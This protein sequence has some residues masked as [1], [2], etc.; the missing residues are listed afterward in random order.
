METYDITAEDLAELVDQ[1]Q[2]RTFAEEISMIE[3]RGGE[4]KILEK[5]RTDRQTGIVSAHKEIRESFFGTNQ[6]KKSKLKSMWEFFLE[7]LNDFTLKILM[8]AAVVSISN[9]SFSI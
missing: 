5:L 7:A 6:K 8:A 1:L 2:Q 9:L 3:S 4:D